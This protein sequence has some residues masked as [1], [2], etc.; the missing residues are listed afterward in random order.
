MN[1]I[2]KE[3]ML[4][5]ILITV[6]NIISLIRG[7]WNIYLFFLF[8]TAM[9]IWIFKPSVLK[10]F[11]YVINKIIFVLSYIITFIL[12]A[13]LYYV[14]FLLFRPI[15]Y[16]NDKRFFKKIDRDLATYYIESKNDWKN[17]MKELF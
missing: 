16:V 4:I 8:V 5:L 12:I 1:R 2:R 13:I 3:N 15:L 14:I 17:N 7:E 10:P 9:I 11:T 6:M